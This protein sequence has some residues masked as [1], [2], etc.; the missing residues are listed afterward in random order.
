MVSLKDMPGFSTSKKLDK[1]GMRGSNTCELV[2]E[3]C[4]VPGK[5]P[6]NKGIPTLTP[7]QVGKSRHTITEVHGHHLHYETQLDCGPGA[8]RQL[9]VLTTDAAAVCLPA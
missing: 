8:A 4:K 6:G 3:D 7:L 5:C 9:S 1:L 2:F